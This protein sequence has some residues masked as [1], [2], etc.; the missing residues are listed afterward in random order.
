[1]LHNRGLVSL[2]SL[3]LQYYEIFIYDLHRKQI[4]SE[5]VFCAAFLRLYTQ[6]DKKYNIETLSSITVLLLFY[7]IFDYYLLIFHLISVE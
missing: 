4:T 2:E 6:N 7:Y 5:I 3:R 1:M